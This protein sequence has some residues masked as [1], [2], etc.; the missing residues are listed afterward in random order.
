MG[1]DEEEEEEKN[2]LVRSDGKSEEHPA[3]AV[4][5]AFAR[6]IVIVV[7]T[8]ARLSQGEGRSDIRE[9]HREV[10][11]HLIPTREL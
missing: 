6:T 10:P 4:K 3:V 11:R 9:G 8:N 2:E 7:E 5:V 1:R